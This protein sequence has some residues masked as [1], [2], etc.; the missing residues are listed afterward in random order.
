MLCACNQLLCVHNSCHNNKNHMSDGKTGSPILKLHML[1]LQYW[2]E[3]SEQG[4][5]K[6]NREF[7]IKFPFKKLRRSLAFWQNFRSDFNVVPPFKRLLFPESFG[8]F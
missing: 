1:K 7:P 3:T 8:K 6:E 2:E 5:Q 4:Y